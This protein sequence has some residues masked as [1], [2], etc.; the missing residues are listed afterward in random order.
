MRPT[1]QHL[2]A[3][4]KPWEEIL[5]SKAMR[6]VLSCDPATGGDTSFVRLP[7]GWQGRAGAHY[8][9]DFEE[10]LVLSGDVD[11]NGEGDVLGAG[12]YLYRPGGI[13]HGRVDRS[14]GGADIIIKMGAATDLI[15]V[16]QPLHRHEYDHPTARKRDGRPHIVHFK[17]EAEPW[18]PWNGA[19]RKILSR[20]SESGAETLLIQIGEK[21]D[22]PIKLGGDAGWEWV[23]LAGEFRLA[24]G[25]AFGPFSY[26]YRPKGACG[27]S[28]I[29]GVGPQGCTVMAWREP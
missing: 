17:T 24:D 26:S 15:S 6:K 18:R 21:L 11:L 1:I 8:H 16:G 25:S 12:S 13:V 29:S 19:Q 4:Q 22:A 14:T 9:S 5:D 7:A 20:N 2:D 23:V 28:V 27:D 3:D 10:A